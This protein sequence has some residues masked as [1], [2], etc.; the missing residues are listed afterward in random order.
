MKMIER[1]VK[2]L[3]FLSMLFSVM[4]VAGIPMIVLG[5]SKGIMPVMIIGIIFTALGFYGTPMFWVSYGG[6]VGLK[7]LVYAVTEEHLLT[8]Q[9]I[10]SQLSKSEKEVRSLLDTC[11]QKG[12]LSGFVRKGDELA[13]NEA[14]APSE[15][16]HAAECQYCGAKFTYKG[17]CCLSLLR[18]DERG[19]K[20]GMKCNKIFCAAL[21]A[22]V[23]AGMVGCSGKN[24]SIED[25]EWQFS[26]LQNT[27]DG[28]VLYCSEELA[29]NWPE[30]EV[31]DMVCE[32]ADGAITFVSGEREW[33]GTYEK[34]GEEAIGASLYRADF[35]EGEAT[36]LT[37]GAIE[38]A[39]G[40]RAETLIVSGRK[41]TLNFIAAPN[42][43]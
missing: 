6:K 18:R 10:A 36:F 2:K 26:T 40:T 27:S 35:G 13:L 20:A 21:L 32:A 8:V 30:A 4:F 5:A 23:F 9:E 11:F 34:Y 43:Q 15:K 29:Q 33:S 19:K 22:A 14:Q 41:Y 39:D 38:Y 12:Y 16:L 17:T 42:I 37:V 28:K 24:Y 7:R 25:K 1:A 3:F 31:L